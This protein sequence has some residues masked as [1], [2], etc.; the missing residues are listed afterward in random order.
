MIGWLD[1]ETDDELHE[2]DLHMPAT[3]TKISQS[4]LLAT[5]LNT[6]TSTPP[7]PPTPNAPNP[8]CPPHAFDALGTP[9]STTSPHPRTRSRARPT[10]PP[11]R[12]R[13]KE[14][15][16]QRNTETQT[17]ALFDLRVRHARGPAQPVFFP[18][19]RS[20]FQDAPLLFKMLCYVILP[21]RYRLSTQ[22]HVARIPR[23]VSQVPHRAQTVQT[24]MA[25]IEALP[26]PR[27]MYVYS[28]HTR[29]HEPSAWRLVPHPS[30]RNTS[31][32][33]R[34]SISRIARRWI[35]MSRRST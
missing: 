4:R 24:S 2:H 30:R 35:S 19:S 12:L 33:S 6:P 27:Y 18:Q 34:C 15:M 28:V 31:R 9:T 23:H 5:P 20:F 10:T 26:G 14:T 25:E 32:R 1:G 8:Q 7:L 21:I 29:A 3:H 11:R 22:R 16:S 13:R 17:Q